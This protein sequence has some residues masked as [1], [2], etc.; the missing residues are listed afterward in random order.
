M[1]I[2]HWLRHR[3]AGRQYPPPLLLSI[4]P[5]RGPYRFFARTLPLRAFTS[6]PRWLSISAAVVQFV[7]DEQLKLRAP[8]TLPW[9]LEVSQGQGGAVWLP[10]S[11]SITGFCTKDRLICAVVDCD[12]ELCGMNEFGFWEYFIEVSTVGVEQPD[13]GNLLF[14][15]RTSKSSM[16]GF[17]E[18]CRHS[19]QGWVDRNRLIL[20]DVFKRSD[21]TL[22]HT[23]TIPP[24]WSRRV[25]T[26][27]LLG[28]IM[29]DN[30]INWWWCGE[31]S[32]FMFR[33]D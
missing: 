26:S 11:G 9:I 15:D 6:K 12:C 1:K 17:E 13:T 10:K 19:W 16:R 14:L 18:T 8:R 29:F 20:Q 31:Q 33:I 4:R 2:D 25:V 30:P 22:S 3:G 23:T 7:N 27:L 32:G 24:N 28:P 5:D 21:Y